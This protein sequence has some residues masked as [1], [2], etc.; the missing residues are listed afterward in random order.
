MRLPPTLKAEE[1]K[2]KVIER[3][4]NSNP[5]NANLKLDFIGAGTGFNAP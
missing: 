2:E 5:F 3:V 1:A 4:L